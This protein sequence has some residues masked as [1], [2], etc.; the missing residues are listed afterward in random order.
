MFEELRGRCGMQRNA[1]LSVVR[2]LLTDS[3]R[4]TGNIPG[5]AL[6]DRKA[7]GLW[8][9]PEWA[10]CMGQAYRSRKHPFLA[11]ATPPLRHCLQAGEQRRRWERHAI[12][13]FTACARYS[14]RV[15]FAGD[16]DFRP[17]PEASASTAGSGRRIT[18]G[19]S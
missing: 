2:Q 12:C 3:P 17:C 7:Q 15:G 19:T 5:A 11:R 4:S 13:S 14:N 1:V 16:P 18:Y 8:F 6:C 10:P 9:A